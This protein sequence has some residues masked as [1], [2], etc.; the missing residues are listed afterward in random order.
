MVNL[1]PLNYFAARKHFKME[2]AGML[3]SLLQK[4]DWITIIDLKDAFLSV[5]IQEDHRKLLRFQ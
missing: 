4:N 2:N 1:K 5:A 3:R